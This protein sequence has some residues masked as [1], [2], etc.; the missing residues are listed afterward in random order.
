M[1]DE[2]TYD[3]TIMTAHVE[4]DDR[5]NGLTLAIGVKL[6]TGAMFTARHAT[7]GE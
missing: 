1:T 5:N 2:G 7:S 3:A 6:S 4:V